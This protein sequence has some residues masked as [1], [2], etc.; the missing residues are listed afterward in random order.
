MSELSTDTTQPH[1]D[2]RRQTRRR[3]LA[4]F[5]YYFSENRGA[6]IGLFVFAALIVIA[7][8]APLIAPHPPNFQNRDALLVP[9]FWQEGGSGS[10]ICWAPMPSAATS[11]RA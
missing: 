10:N 1:A 7:V 11:S 6:V 4:E 5:W 9:P 3:M 8:L 2:V